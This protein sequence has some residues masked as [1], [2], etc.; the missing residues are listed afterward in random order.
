MSI[1]GCQPVH[2]SHRGRSPSAARVADELVKLDTV[3]DLNN[4][5]LRHVRLVDGQDAKLEL[6]DPAT[7][8]YPRQGEWISDPHESKF[9]FT[10]MIPSWNVRTPPQTGVRFY[11][12]TRDSKTGNWSPWLYVGYWGHLPPGMET[13]RFSGGKVSIDTLRLTRPANAWRICAILESLATDPKINPVIDRISVCYTGL[14]SDPEILAKIYGPF[15]H[16]SSRPAAIDLPVPY[17][18]Q[19]D[20]PGA[21]RGQT[22]SPTSVSMV[23]AYWGKDFPTPV[24]FEAI[25][26]EQYHLFGNWNRAVARAGEVGLDAWVTHFRSWGQVRATL[27]SGQPIIAAIKFKPGEFPSSVL[28]SSAGHLIVIRGITANGD[29]ICN[30]PGRRGVGNHAI[31]KSSELGHAWFIRGDGVAY[32]IHGNHAAGKSSIDTENKQR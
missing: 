2:R 14:T 3:E 12:Q 23:M 27:A 4:A 28:K 29:I 30:D 1:L 16:A 17:R 8:D 22:C 20:N 24:N 6:F 11:V 18:P 32:I 26:D 7:A 19:G 10:E 21:T 9:A 13:T 15:T 25:W 5:T 31:Y